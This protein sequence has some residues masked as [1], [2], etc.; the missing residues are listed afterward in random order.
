VRGGTPATIV[1]GF[2]VRGASPRARGNPWQPSPARRDLGCIPACAGEPRAGAVRQ[3][4]R[5][6]H[7]RVRG[8]TIPTQ[9]RR[10]LARGASPR[11]RG[12]PVQPERRD[13]PRGCIPA[14]A[15][16]PRA[17]RPQRAGSGVHPRVRG[18]T[19]AWSSKVVRGLGASPRA[20][21]NPRVLGVLGAG[22]GCIPACAGEPLRLREGEPGRRVHPRVRGGTL[23]A[24]VYDRLK[25]GA[26][27]RARGNRPLNARVGVLKGCI[28][29][30]AGEPQ[31][32]PLE[33]ER[34]RVHPRVRGGTRR[35][36]GAFDLAKGASPRA[37]GNPPACRFPP[38]SPGCIPA[39]AGEPPW[40]RTA[41]DPPRVHPRVRGGTGGTRV[42][43]RRMSGASPR[44]R[45]NRDG[46]P[47]LHQ[48]AGCIPACAGEPRGRSARLPRCG[49]HP[50]VR[51][52]TWSV[53]T[54]TPH[55]PGASPRA[56]GNRRVAGRVARLVGC[57][58]ACAGEPWSRSST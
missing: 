56:R 3:S 32:G 15:G 20:R 5:G 23:G 14:C 4:A 18:G 37:R 53:L 26:S 7:P 29:A 55:C 11:A 17:R 52:G 54:S 41:T 30:C 16:E 45:G 44:A 2:N 58:P 12:N 21:G 46:G 39:C 38:P 40:R 31:P 25:E 19:S 36:V 13:V 22:L 10:L 1:C 9:P 8:G 50:R 28:P 48:R 35:T 34:V 33:T 42:C 47:L 51:G 49:V 57:I 6:V 43:F 24:G 27:P